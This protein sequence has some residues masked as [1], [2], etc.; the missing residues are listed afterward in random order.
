MGDTGDCE[1]VTGSTV[2]NAKLLCVI[3]FFFSCPFFF[4][5]V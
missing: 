4:F 5:T 2:T 3:L 1:D